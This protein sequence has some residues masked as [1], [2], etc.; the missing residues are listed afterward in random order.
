MRNFLSEC[1]SLVVKFP[2]EITQESFQP[3]FPRPD[4]VCQKPLSLYVLFLTRAA[5][6]FSVIFFSFPRHGAHSKLV[7][8]KPGCHNSFSSF[9]GGTFAIAEHD[10]LPVIVAVLGEPIFFRFLPPGGIFETRFQ[11]LPRIGWIRRVKNIF[12]F[13]LSKRLFQEIII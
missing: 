10:A 4:K 2:N 8:Q 9:R 6:R 5:Q 1:S 11:F 7:E 13:L 3:C 12:S